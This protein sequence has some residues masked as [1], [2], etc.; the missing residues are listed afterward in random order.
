MSPRKRFR[1]SPT[2]CAG[3]PFSRSVAA[4][5]A[6]ALA[7]AGRVAAREVGIAARWIG[8]AARGA[9]LVSGLVHRAELV[10]LLAQARGPAALEGRAGGSAANVGAGEDA[11]RACSWCTCVAD[12][13]LGGGRAETDRA[14]GFG[15]CKRRSK[16]RRRRRWAKSDSRAVCSRCTRSRS[17]KS[18]RTPDSRRHCSRR[19]R[20][21]GSN[22]RR[23]A[24]VRSRRWSNR[25]CRRFPSQ[26][27]SPRDWSSHSP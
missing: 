13:A 3:G 4:Q 21:K 11:R 9:E 18:W 20:S 5:P 22:C 25:C 19:R 8:G 27:R 10:R 2:P 23:T 16:R 15:S 17:C 7:V 12:A 26:C 6:A 14:R 24:L 1:L